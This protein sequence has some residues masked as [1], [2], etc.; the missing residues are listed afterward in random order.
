M[1]VRRE[2]F[3][4]VGLFSEVAS[5][6]DREFGQRAQSAG[7]ELAWAPDA[8]VLHPARQRLGDLLRKMRRLEGGEADTRPTTTGQRLREGL[9]VPWDLIRSRRQ[10]HGFGP[11]TTAR[12]VAVLGLVKAVRLGERLRVARG[13]ARERR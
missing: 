1:A 5:I 2:V 8:V 12:G 3:D 4:D 13:G 9:H 6:G 7:H 10:Q 11:L